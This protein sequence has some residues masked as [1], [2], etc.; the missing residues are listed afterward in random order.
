MNPF[1]KIFNYQLMSRLEDSGTF[2]VTGNE[3]SWL[4]AMLQHP[5]AVQAF[6]PGT[7]AK[8]ESLLEQDSVMETA[9]PLIQ[10]AASKEMQV[11]HPLLRQLRRSIMQRNQIKLSYMIKNGRQ[12]NHQ[13]GVPYKLEYSMVK[14]EWY[15]LW[16]HQRHRSLMSTKLQTI[17]A[18]EDVPC[19]P[20]RYIQLTASTQ[21]LLAKRSTTAIIQVV[22][23]YNPEL[24]R[25]LYAFSCF[26]KSVSYDDQLNRYTIELTFPNNE[27]EYVL[28]KIRFLGKR[29]KVTQGDYLQRRMREASSLALARYGAAKADIEPE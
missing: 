18:I 4:K 13:S 2:M 27:A 9:G 19:P 17:L 8:L 23:M 16:Y 28:S 6:A 25:I 7:L 5:E 3:R 15:L 21:A 20:E 26:E 12:N 22:E 14:K 11:Y 29:I 1:E 10:K 24:S